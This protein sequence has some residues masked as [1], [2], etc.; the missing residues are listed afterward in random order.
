MDLLIAVFGLFVAVYAILPRERQLDIK[1]RLGVTDWVALSLGLLIVLFVDFYKFFVIHGLRVAR[2]TWTNGITA[3]NIDHVAVLGLIS[4]FVIRIRSVR[5][6]RRTISKFNRLAQELLWAGRDT[7]LIELVGGHLKQLFRVYHS[8]RWML[9]LRRQIERALGPRLEDFIFQ[10]D[11]EA[12][13]NVSGRLTR[14]LPRPAL[15][16]SLALLPEHDEKS[17][18]AQE[19]A[20]SVLLSR[21][22]IETVVRTK[23]YLGLGVIDLWNDGFYSS[24]FIDLYLTELLRNPGSILY[25]E[26]ANNQNLIGRNRY[27]IPQS[28]RLIYYLL[29]DASVAEKL[30]VY[31]PMGDFSL[32]ELD[33]LGRDHSEDPYNLAMDNDFSEKEAWRSPIFI[34][35][36]FFDIMVME[37]L[38]QGIEWHMWLYYFPRIVEKMVRNFKIV[39]PL[40]DPYAEWPTRYS[41]LIYEIFSALRNWVESVEDVPGDQGNVRLGSMRADHENGNI[42]KSSILALGECVRPVLESNELGEDFQDYLMDIA[43][44]LYFELSESEEGAQFA[45]VLGNALRQGGT[46]RRR[47]DQAYR[48][49][50]RESFA[51]QSTEYYIKHSHKTVTEF[52]ASLSAA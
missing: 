31:K 25:V 35:I 46:R 29:S 20:R 13:L 34:T 50:L 9:R 15:R 37:A 48:S 24:R 1:L 45:V 26:L 27:Q 39:D 7:E 38:F 40:T 36:R 19:C 22:F 41:F 2:P 16:R 14:L 42:P 5:L 23:P 47:E 17:Q 52:E 4:F 51:R 44:R 8:D 12:D 43:F 6:S 28:N 3:A 32:S 30:G 21:Q 49:R 33:R 18:I 11:S 10:T